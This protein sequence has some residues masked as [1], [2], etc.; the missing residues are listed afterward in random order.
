MNT[1][2]GDNNDDDADADAD[3]DDDDDDDDDDDVDSTQQNC[4]TNIP[5]LRWSKMAT[6]PCDMLIHIDET[7]LQSA[8]PENIMTNNQVKKRI[9]IDIKDTL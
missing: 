2:N 8:A 3:A 9:L 4:G 6:S 1:N 7:F 5:E